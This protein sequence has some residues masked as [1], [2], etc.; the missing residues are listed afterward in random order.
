MLGNSP[1]LSSDITCSTVSHSGTLTTR[2]TRNE[3]G[4]TLEEIVRED[5]R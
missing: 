4:E 3:G 1:L 2:K 5:G